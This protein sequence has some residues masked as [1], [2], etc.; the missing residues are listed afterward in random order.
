V[1]KP[2]DI[3]KFYN[4]LAFLIKGGYNMQNI[5]VSI[6]GKT[7]EDTE[8]FEGYSDNSLPAPHIALVKDE[9]IKF[10]DSTPYDYRFIKQGGVPFLRVYRGERYEDIPAIPVLTDE[11]D[12]Y[13]GYFLNGFD[14]AEIERIS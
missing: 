3:W 4:N 6:D 13:E 7:D 1:Q 14:L 9:V 12:I 2:P 8:I 11:G 5:K 10:L